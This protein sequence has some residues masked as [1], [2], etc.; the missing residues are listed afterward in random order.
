MGAPGPPAAC[1]GRP[2]RKEARKC[3][4]EA[5]STHRA[6]GLQEDTGA[7]AGVFTGAFTAVSGLHSGLSKTVHRPLHGRVDRTVISSVGMARPHRR[8]GCAFV[9]AWLHEHTSGR[10]DEGGRV[11]PP[12]GTCDLGAGEQ[13]GLRVRKRAAERIGT[14]AGVRAGSAAPCAVP[15]PACAHPCAPRDGGAASLP[16]DAPHPTPV[17]CTGGGGVEPPAGCTGGGGSE[18]A[19]ASPTVQSV[20]S[21]QNVAALRRKAVADGGAAGGV[22]AEPARWVARD[23]YGNQL[24]SDSAVSPEAARQRQTAAAAAACDC[25]SASDVTPPPPFTPA[26]TPPSNPRLRLR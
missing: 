12:V 23:K 13:A 14:G 15:P 3:R 6:S 9:F 8:T 16:G 24:A 1:R 11:T 18:P 10:G 5:D 2:C 7:E 17:G 22:C 26:F 25:A 21:R 20:S 19:P 4:Q